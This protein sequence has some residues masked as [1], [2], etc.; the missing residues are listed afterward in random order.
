MASQFTVA[1][2]VLF[3]LTFH[4]SS[5]A[6]AIDSQACH[7]AFDYR[8]SDLHIQIDLYTRC[9][10]TGGLSTENKVAIYNNRGAIYNDLKKYDRAID[11]YNKAIELAP[12]DAGVYF[13]MGKSYQKLGQYDRSI[14]NYSKAI[15]LNPH[16][17]E[18]YNNFAFLLAT[19]KDKKYIDGRK[20]LQFA[21]KAVGLSNNNPANWDTLAAAYAELGEFS[22]AIGAQTKAV[23]ILKSKGN[24]ASAKE[25]GKVL[26][27]YERGKKYY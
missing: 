19:T 14:A 11:D 6:S 16:Y 15:E 24:K 17:A 22:K 26:E 2:A 25:Y 10:T 27:Y 8:G 18:A 5:N 9:L 12:E 3:S 1:L 21:L 13:N 20:A 23:L 7:D 4:F